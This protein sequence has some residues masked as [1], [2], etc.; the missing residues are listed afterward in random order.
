MQEDDVRQKMELAVEAVKEDLSSIRTGRATPALVEAIVV[1]TYGGS[2]KLKIVELATIT[3]PD[4]RTILISPW[5]KSVVFDIKR[6]VEE[7]KSGLN[8]VINDDVIRVSLAPMTAEDRESYTKLLGQKLENGKISIRRVRAEAMGEV[9][10]AFERKEF[11]EDEKFSREERV[12]KLTDEYVG[13][14]EE[15]GKTKEQELQQV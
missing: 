13:K 1:T 3:T 8:P 14:I 12:Q 11:G 4:P 2:Q 10:S 7:N 6:A 5:D 15:M 9:G